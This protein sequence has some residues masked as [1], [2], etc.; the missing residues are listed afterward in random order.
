MSPWVSALLRSLLIG[1]LALMNGGCSS[2]FSPLNKP[3]DHTPD[4]NGY[5]FNKAR[6]GKLGENLVLLTFSGGGTRAA[7]LAY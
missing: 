4:G 6:G 3:L 5:G 1:L 7:A 2:L